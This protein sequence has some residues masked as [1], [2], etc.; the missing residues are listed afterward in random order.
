M[1][2]SSAMQQQRSRFK[3]SVSLEEQFAE[4]A[5]L[6]RDEARL[7][8]QGAVRDAVIRKAERE[9]TASRWVAAVAGLQPPK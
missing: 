6:L 2:W 9:E 1:E 3:Q 4:E 7:L 5:K 8:P